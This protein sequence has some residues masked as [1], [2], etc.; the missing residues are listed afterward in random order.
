[1]L[2]AITMR[3]GRETILYFL[4]Q[5]IVNRRIKLN[6]YAIVRAVTFVTFNTLIG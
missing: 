3:A 4:G 5:V 1:M 2:V 6:E